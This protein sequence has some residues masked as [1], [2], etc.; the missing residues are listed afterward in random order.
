MKRCPGC[1]TICEDDVQYCPE[2]GLILLP[3]LADD[4][5]P[6]DSEPDEN[7]QR[8]LQERVSRLEKPSELG[9]QPEPPANIPGLELGSIA[10]WISLLLLLSGL[11]GFLWLLVRAL[12]M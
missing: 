2:C 8:F 7:T 9:N 1:N 12:E 11:G 4:F 5:V 10:R 3:D 6:V